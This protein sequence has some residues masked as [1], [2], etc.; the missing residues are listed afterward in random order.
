MSEEVKIMMAA[1]IKDLEKVPAYERNFEKIVSVLMQNPIL[2]PTAD[3][4]YR[5]DQ[6]VRNSPSD[7]KFDGSASAPIVQEVSLVDFCR[8]RPV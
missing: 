2:E 4:N 8:R 7:I 3:I 1:T 6:V 5:E